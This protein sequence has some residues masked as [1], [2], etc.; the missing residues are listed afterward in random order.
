MPAL[1]SEA[2][3]STKSAFVR[4]AWRKIEV[5]GKS[6]SGFTGDKGGTGDWDHTA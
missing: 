4:L 2:M 6:P 1:H 3:T 5:N